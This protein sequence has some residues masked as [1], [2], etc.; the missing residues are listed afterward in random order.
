KQSVI[1]SDH[2]QEKLTDQL[3]QRTTAGP[4]DKPSAHLRCLLIN[5]AFPT[6]SIPKNIPLLQTIM[7]EKTYR[8]ASRII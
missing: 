3:N 8:V 4:M 6:P 2:A 5:F 7:R 1:A